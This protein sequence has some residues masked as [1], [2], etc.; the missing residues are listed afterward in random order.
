M[1]NPHISIVTPIYGYC[2]S[3]NNLYTNTK[4]NF[5]K[6]KNYSNTGSNEYK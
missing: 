3:L 5:S 6:I 1:N 4:L 2:K